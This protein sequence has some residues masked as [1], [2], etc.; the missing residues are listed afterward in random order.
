MCELFEARNN[1]SRQT[2]YFRRFPTFHHH[3]VLP[4]VRHHAVHSTCSGQAPFIL[5]TKGGVCWLVE[6]HRNLQ[7]SLNVARHR[8][9]R[10]T[11]TH[12][13]LLLILF[14]DPRATFV[15]LGRRRCAHMGVPIVFES[16]VA[17]SLVNASSKVCSRFFFSCRHQIAP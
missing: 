10:P 11:T 15:A 7:V 1:T 4:H 16:V 5:N 3:H 8:N 9:H 13:K 17:V 12:P 2:P 14:P 6:Q